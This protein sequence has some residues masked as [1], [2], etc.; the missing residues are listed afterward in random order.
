MKNQSL[1]YGVLGIIVG[2]LLTYLALTQTKATPQEHTMSSDQHTMNGMVDELKG[3]E[4]DVF[5]ETFLSTMIEHHQGAIAMA[6]EAKKHAAH[7]ELKTMADDIITA[8][9]KEIKQMQQWQDEWG[10]HN[11]H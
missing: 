3:K 1:I 2:S 4:G 8:Q 6:E 7:D 9:S 10:Y 11:Q 5:D